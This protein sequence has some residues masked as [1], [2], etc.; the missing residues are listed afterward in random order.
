MQTPGST[1]DVIECKQLS[2]ACC[3]HH[4]LVPSAHPNCCPC[5]RPAAEAVCFPPALLPSTHLRWLPAERGEGGSPER[6]A[7]AV[8]TCRGVSVSA[9]FTFD[10]E[11][12]FQVG[13]ALRYDPVLPRAF[14]A[15]LLL[16]DVL[17]T[18]A[19]ADRCCRC[20]L[21][22]LATHPLPLPGACVA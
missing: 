15:A 8:L 19:A 21:S 2:A 13:A 3:F 22:P 1:R 6:S 4:C 5:V 20:C 18:A 7:R 16:A 12:R 11:G 10:G 17:V 14:A 9:L